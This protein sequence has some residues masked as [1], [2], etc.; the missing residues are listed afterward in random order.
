MFKEPE[1]FEFITPA[2]GNVIL[3]DG[4]TSLPIIGVGTVKCF[5]GDDFD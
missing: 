2:K 1:F 3:G 4:K 5:L